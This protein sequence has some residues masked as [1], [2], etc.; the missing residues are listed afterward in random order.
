MEKLKCPR[1]GS[2]NTTMIPN[3]K[4]THCGGDKWCLDCGKI[5]DK[6]NREEKI[7]ISL[8]ENESHEPSICD[9]C[10][11]ELSKAEIKNNEDTCYPCQ[12]GN[13]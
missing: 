5:F 7:I 8:E 11:D 6:L 1:C 3:L 10:G 9:S 2:R 4:E 13:R 12:K